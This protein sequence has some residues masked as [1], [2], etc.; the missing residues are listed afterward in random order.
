MDKFEPFFLKWH[1][2]S[3]DLLTNKVRKLENER[4]RYR[5][6]FVTSIIPDLVGI[7]I[8]V[9]SVPQGSLLLL[10]PHFSIWY[11]HSALKMEKK[12]QVK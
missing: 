7:S 2:T 5:I 12:V 8:I 11:Y 10:I 6:F 4:R 3:P 1:F 9:S